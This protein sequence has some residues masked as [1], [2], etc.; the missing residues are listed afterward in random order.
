MKIIHILLPLPVESSVY[1]YRIPDYVSVPPLGIFVSVP[2]KSRKMI[3]IVWK[4]KIDDR[5][6]LEKIKWVS[7]IHWDYRLPE[8]LVRMIRFVSAYT[9]S[10]LGA[11]LKLA[12]PAPETIVHPPYTA[13]YS[14]Q[15]PTV[16]CTRLTPARKRILRALE[17]SP[18]QKSSLM[19]LSKTSKATIDRLTQLGIIRESRTL[20][21]PRQEFPKGLDTN[22]ALSPEQQ[23]ATDTIA[24]YFK[25]FKSIV[26]D[27]VPGSG[28]TEI[29]F[30][31][32]CQV[33]RDNGQVLVLL[34]EIAL[35][36]QWL[37][38]FAQRFG[39][40]ACV[41]HSKI[42]Q[43]N[44]R[45]IWIGVAHGAIKIVVGARSALY[46]PF[47]HLGLIVVDEEHETTYKQESGVLY[48]TRD[49]AIKRASI[50]ACPILLCS[51]TPSL[52]TWHNI[53]KRSYVHI[54]IPRRF[55]G[56]PSPK[57]T[58]LDTTTEKMERGKYMAPT[59]HK[60]VK[61][62]LENGLQTL[63]F[64]NRR[65]YA[66]LLVCT[67]CGYKFECRNC[68]SWLVF[69]QHNRKLL[70]HHCDY[71]LEEPFLCLGCGSDNTFFSQGAGVERICKEVRQQHPSA[72]TYIATSETLNTIDRTRDFLRKMERG[73]IDIV[74]STQILAKGY[75]FDKLT[76]VGVIDGD[77]I[78]KGGDLRAGERT[79]Q[80]LH[81][82]IG[83]SGRKIAVGQAFIQTQDPENPVLTALADDKRNTFLDKELAQRRYYRQPPFAR[84]IAIIV[85]DTD[86]I[87]CQKVSDML[88]KKAPIIKNMRIFG[89][90]EP[91]MSY[92]RGRYR[93]RFLINVSKIIDNR[94]L[95]QEI[96]QWI[97]E[98]KPLD[99]A[100]R[101][102]IDVD[103]QS[104][105]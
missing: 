43:K 87:R 40:K 54:E 72:R 102:Q 62:T 23:K 63:L 28:K 77:M 81:Q 57:I 92:L 83:R 103:P 42:T 65:G 11:V 36:E 30:K 78:L 19:K 50:A 45:E 44:R 66:P 22:I 99:R 1:C 39:I 7:K 35:S 70:C 4:K 68:R 101:I 64:L 16:K 3:G 84:L 90:A 24:K 96:Q 32:I 91:Y 59:L 18:L 26:L 51:A 29:Y 61:N 97:A 34:P 31:S 9:M 67:S 5:M 56:N 75:H 74:I 17:P 20:D 27:G 105:L 12:M 41:W 60:H 82:V 86:V 37:E 95:T 71:A 98:I 53:K 94:L 100:T 47:T 79:F 104:F 69:H 46:L 55:S 13:T 52:E 89:P 25:T 8:N 10:P 80:M 76:L 6:A 15:K 2:V 48:N 38:R 33:L 14:L 85:T 88:K 58:L 73:H 21:I 49:M 93:R